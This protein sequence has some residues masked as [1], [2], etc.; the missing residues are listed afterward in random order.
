[1]MSAN[2]NLP[3]D[4]PLDPLVHESSPEVLTAVASDPRLT[5]DLARLS[6]IG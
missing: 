2:L 1:M 4:A 3:E 6:E 5:E